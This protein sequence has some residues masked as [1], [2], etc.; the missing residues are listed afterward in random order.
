VRVVANGGCFFFVAYLAL[1][2]QK[3]EGEGEDKMSG[4][5][6][7][8]TIGGKNGEPKRVSCDSLSHLF[9]C[10]YLCLLRGFF[11]FI[12]FRPWHVL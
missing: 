9:L 7:S 10:P 6:I 8:T 2:M 12:L 1:V 3:K 5:I 11:D 4:H